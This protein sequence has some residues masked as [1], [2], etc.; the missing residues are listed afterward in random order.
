VTQSD[1]T[2]AEDWISLGLQAQSD[3]TYQEAIRCFLTAK[4]Q[5]EKDPDASRL[6]DLLEVYKQLGKLYFSSGLINK[7]IFVL[8]K[9]MLLHKACDAWRIDTDL[10]EIFQLLAICYQQIGDYCY[11]DVYLSN[12][13]K[14]LTI[15][16]LENQPTMQASI[17]ASRIHFLVEF[18]RAADEC[19]STV[20]REESFGRLSEYCLEAELAL[21]E[22]SAADFLPA[23]QLRF[24]LSETHLLQK[25]NDDAYSL[26][27]ES[28]KDLERFMGPEHPILFDFLMQQAHCEA[29]LTRYEELEATLRR[30][31]DIAKPAFGPDSSRLIE[32]I[33]L[34]LRCPNLLFDEGLIAECAKLINVEVSSNDQFIYARYACDSFLHLRMAQAGQKATKSRA[35]LNLLSPWVDS[36]SAVTFVPAPDF[37]HEENWLA[38]YRR[39]NILIHETYASS[40]HYLSIA[41]KDQRKFKEQE[42]CL[43]Q[44][45][46]IQTKLL[47]RYPRYDSFSL[48]MKIRDADE[49]SPID[50]DLAKWLSVRDRLDRLYLELG[51]SLLNQNC[52]R[53]SREAFANVS[54][55]FFFNKLKAVS[56]SDIELYDIYATYLRQ[57]G[58]SKLADSIESQILNSLKYSALRVLPPI[59]FQFQ[60]FLAGVKLRLRS[61][62]TRGAIDA[63]NQKTQPLI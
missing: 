54:E 57:S 45:I 61:L 26:I 59:K 43:K 6:P 56:L 18:I 13:Y 49:G 11:A 22:L 27:H 55:S 25:R 36:Q 34:L 48:E 21:Q 23:A 7:A 9:A 41:L 35:V 39:T 15:I 5:I 42:A 1:I 20:D 29:A 14:R 52:A 19:G 8:T 47:L 51:E 28:I 44:A 50:P 53:D 12:A 38:S 10:V 62:K 37:T 3:G 46:K 30:T 63:L 16:G 33:I 31:I 24:A 17:V 58:Q 60:L 32:C 2:R 4:A 40:A